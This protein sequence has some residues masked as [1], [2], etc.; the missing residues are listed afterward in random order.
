MKIL[1]IENFDF[2]FFSHE[3]GRSF[4]TLMSNKYFHD[5]AYSFESMDV[6]LN[7]I[8]DFLDESIVLPPGDYASRNLLSVQE[9]TEMRRRKKERK[10]AMQKEAEMKKN[11][12]N[13]SLD[14]KMVYVTVSD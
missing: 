13:K 6:L 11:L 7:A 4:S 12:S 9:I 3:V 8:N 5:L 14:G 10:E 1:P 2:I